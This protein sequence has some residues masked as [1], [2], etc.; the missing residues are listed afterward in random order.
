MQS[1]IKAGAERDKAQ[2]I[3][4]EEASRADY[5][6]SLAGFRAWFRTQCAKEGVRYA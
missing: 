5:R 2:R 3:A 4:R 6:A 1:W